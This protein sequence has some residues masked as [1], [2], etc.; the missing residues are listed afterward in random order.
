M[1]NEAFSQLAE[2]KSLDLVL[3]SEEFRDSVL[4]AGLSVGSTFGIEGLLIT[5]GIR[6][7]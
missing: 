6:L 2:G 5:T 4:N 7:P 3:G 1:A